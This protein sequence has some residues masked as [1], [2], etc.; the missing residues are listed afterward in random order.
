MGI[1]IYMYNL[2]HD[3]EALIALC[4]QQT[5]GYYF[6]DMSDASLILQLRF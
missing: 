2:V 3:E 1:D 6:R 5:C 4:K